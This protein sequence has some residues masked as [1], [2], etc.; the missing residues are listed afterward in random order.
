MNPATEE[1]FLLML[2]DYFG[3]TG[4]IHLAPP[5]EKLSQLYV[6]LGSMRLAI[7]AFRDMSMHT[8]CKRICHPFVRVTFLVEEWNFRKEQETKDKERV[9]LMKQQPKPL[10]L[11]SRGQRE[12]SKYVIRRTDEGAKKQRGIARLMNIKRGTK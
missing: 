1:W 7:V 5:R 6:E 10:A 3:L 4:R 8:Q 2:R 9:T 12:Q 11:T